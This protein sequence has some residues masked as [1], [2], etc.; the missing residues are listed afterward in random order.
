M[1]V[2]FNEVPATHGAAPTAES[3]DGAK[4]GGRVQ[5]RA[6]QL[7]KADPLRGHRLGFV[8]TKPP[9]GRPGR[10]RESASDAEPPGGL[11]ATDGD[12]SAR[13]SAAAKGL[14]WHAD[15][16]SRGLEA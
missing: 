14:G 2:K 11:T 9:P 3:R 8:C 10:K 13:R 15:H 5:E 4:I 7:R 12:T 6:A 1:A 16:R